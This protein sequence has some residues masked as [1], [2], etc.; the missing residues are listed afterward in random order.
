[1]Y[2]VVAP[3]IFAVCKFRLLSEENPSAIV[4]VFNLTNN[5]CQFQPHKTETSIVGVTEIL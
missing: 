4:F 2:S 1:M 3:V 5:N